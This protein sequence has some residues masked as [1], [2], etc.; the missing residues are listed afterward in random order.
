MYQSALMESKDMRP[1]LLR[2]PE[3]CRALSSRTETP[4]RIDPL[5]GAHAPSSTLPY[6]SRSTPAYSTPPFLLEIVRDSAG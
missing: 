5:D 1:R 3:Y 4:F 6:S 2:P